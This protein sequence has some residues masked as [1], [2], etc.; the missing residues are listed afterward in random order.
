MAP[1]FCRHFDAKWKLR[2]YWVQILNK[3]R[4]FKLGSI[5]NWLINFFKVLIRI[6]IG[7]NLVPNKSYVWTEFNSFSILIKN[8][9][10]DIFSIFQNF[11]DKFLL[12]THFYLVPKN[13]KKNSANTLFG[14]SL[15]TL[16]IS[17]RKLKKLITMLSR[18]KTCQLCCCQLCHRGLKVNL[19]LYFNPVDN[20]WGRCRKRNISENLPYYTC[21]VCS[22]FR[23]QW[24][25]SR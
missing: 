11:V 13:R 4:V 23:W 9:F 8:N 18:F 2:I 17:H 1:F 14:F 7:P 6:S 12:N 16:I 19:R 25:Q 20:N 10:Q 24:Q 15:R 5:F 21:L 22:S 3:F